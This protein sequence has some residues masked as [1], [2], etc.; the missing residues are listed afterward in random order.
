MFCRICAGE[1]GRKTLSRFD[2]KVCP[3]ARCSLRLL[4]RPVF[5]AALHERAGVMSDE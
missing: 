3:A 2:L 4:I 1:E 5:T